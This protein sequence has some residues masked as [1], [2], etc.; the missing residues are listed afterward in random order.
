MLYFQFMAQ[1]PQ[2]PEFR[3]VCLSDKEY[4]D[5]A[6]RAFQPEISELTFTN[7][8]MFRHVHDYQLSERR[9]SIIIFAKS[10]S[11]E[12]YF[13]PPIG[14]ADIPLTLEDL[15]EFLRKAGEKPVIE[16][17]CKGFIDK[18]IAGNDKYSFE[19]DEDDSDYLYKTRD[20]VELAGRKYHDK[21]NLLNRF[22]RTYRHEYR[23]LTDDM[24]PDAKDLVHRW[25]QEKCS[26]DIPST[27]GE[28]EATLLALDYFDQLSIKGGAVFVDGKL[29]AIALGEELNEDTA[30]VHVEKANSEYAGLYQYI[31]SR[32]LAHEFPHF[33]YVNREQD[34][35]EPNL[36]KSKQSYN[37]VRMIEKYK[38]WPKD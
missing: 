30:V 24:V 35:G 7:L 19:L 27:F 26:C 11:D 29:E 8:F 36:R 21:K 4:L 20:L 12:P 32:F 9:G 14:G 13:M 17:V 33:K 3:S 34:L 22:V 28:T 5:E 37:P 31:S 25:C 16:L 1:L 18:Y 23:T 38:I 2:F 6:F 15:L 10:Y